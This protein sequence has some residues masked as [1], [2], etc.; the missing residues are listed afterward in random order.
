[1]NQLSDFIRARKLFAF[2]ECREC[3]TP[4]HAG[5]GTDMKHLCARRLL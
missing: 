2:G 5:D 4:G 1:M 3:R